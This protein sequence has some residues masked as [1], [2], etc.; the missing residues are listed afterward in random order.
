MANKYDLVTFYQSMASTGSTPISIGGAVP[1]GKTRFVTYARV[2]KTENIKVSDCSGLTGVLG[3]ASNLTAL[4]A[5][6]TIAATVSGTVLTLGLA[7][8]SGASATGIPNLALMNQCPDRPDMDHP[9]LSVGSG[10]YLYYGRPKVPAASIF[11]QYY[12]E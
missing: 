2:A 8:T 9:L 6:S 5:I 3:V 12:D 11:V 7:E 1:A 10:K 4:S